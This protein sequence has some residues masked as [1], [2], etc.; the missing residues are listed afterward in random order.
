LHDKATRGETLTPVELACLEEWY[1]R[2]DRDE[3]QALAPS[4]S[5]AGLVSLQAQVQAAMVRLQM[6][7]QRIQAQAAE[8]DQLRRE[9][10]TLQ[11]QAVAS[12]PVGPT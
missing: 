2:L 4:T 6:V 1:S 8:N 10:A 5:P 7:T 3:A 9:I 11:R 12:Q